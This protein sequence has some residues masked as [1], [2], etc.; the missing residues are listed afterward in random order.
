MTT[1]EEL[2]DQTNAAINAAFEKLSHQKDAYLAIRDKLFALVKKDHGRLTM[3]E[4]QQEAALYKDLYRLHADIADT[5]QETLQ[6]FRLSPSR[7]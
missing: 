6:I 4:A 5:L 7:E 3:Q 1:N 2:H